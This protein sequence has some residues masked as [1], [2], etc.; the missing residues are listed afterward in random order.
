MVG[1]GWQS[2]RNRRTKG[3]NWGR[4]LGSFGGGN[5][6]IRM[7]WRF[8]GRGDLSPDV[9][10]PMCPVAKLSKPAGFELFQGGKSNQIPVLEK[11]LWE[12]TGRTEP[13]LD[14]ITESARLKVKL[15]LAP[16]KGKMFLCWELGVACREGCQG[17]QLPNARHEKLMP[18]WVLFNH[19]R[20]L[21]FL[22]VSALRSSQGARGVE[23][24]CPH[25]S[26]GQVSGGQ[27]CASERDGWEFL[28]HPV[29]AL[30]TQGP[31]I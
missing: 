25:P 14:G 28:G 11:S 5:A 30:I 21:P 8:W 6:P 3:T 23:S 4:A 20:Q 9:L 10:S 17:I 26:W 22:A 1:R 31:G 2:R 29:L 15:T 16:D 19:K 13:A 18:S 27:A 12:A 7:R 24:V